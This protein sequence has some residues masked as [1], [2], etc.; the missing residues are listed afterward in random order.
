V[1]EIIPERWATSSGISTG[2]PE[3][4]IGST[5]ACKYPHMRI[6]F[7]ETGFGLV[8]VQTGASKQL[9]NNFFFCR[10]IASRHYS[11]ETLHSGSR[12][13]QLKHLAE[14]PFD[15]KQVLTKDY[16]LIYHPVR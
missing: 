1:G 13:L 7:G 8:D 10:F 6:L 3:L 4:I 12:N 2:V 11:L 15:L 16:I 5:Y 14:A 9:G